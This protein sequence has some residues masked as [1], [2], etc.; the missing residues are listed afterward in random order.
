MLK[1]YGKV[2]QCTTS[3][4][5]PMGSNFLYELDT[6]LHYSN[7]S[8]IGHWHSHKIFKFTQVL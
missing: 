8:E 6:Y 2:S 1:N 7:M 3:S 4:I 5:P